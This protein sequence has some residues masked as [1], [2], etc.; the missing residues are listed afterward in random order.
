MAEDSRMPG[1]GGKPE[2]ACGSS[3][4]W[5]GHPVKHAH[6]HPRLQPTRRG[7]GGRD[8]VGI[9]AAE[10][11][12]GSG[13]EGHLRIRPGGSERRSKLP[14]AAQQLGQPLWVQN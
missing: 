7:R 2:A 3:R 5:R 14:E 11:F 8:R 10:R 4:G 13:E 9:T 12:T 1:A 6:P